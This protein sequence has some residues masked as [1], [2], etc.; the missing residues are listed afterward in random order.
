MTIPFDYNFIFLLVEHAY[1][2]Y[3]P[4]FIVKISKYREPLFTDLDHKGA[5]SYKTSSPRR[6]WLPRFKFKILVSRGLLDLN[7]LI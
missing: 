1:M 3:P 6:R 7:G 5:H 4:T 2:V